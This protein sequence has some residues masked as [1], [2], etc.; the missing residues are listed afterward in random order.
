[1]LNLRS[2]FARDERSA[3]RRRSR[4]RL[5]GL[6]QPVAQLLLELGRGVE[7]AERRETADLLEP[8][9][10]QEQVAGAVQDGPELRA[11]A[12]SSIPRSSSVATADSAPT[13]RI[14]AISGRETGCR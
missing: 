8:E 6:Q 2:S 13:P 14:R 12:S 7:L 1:M 11:A 9:Q 5:S 4:A 3:A 10:P